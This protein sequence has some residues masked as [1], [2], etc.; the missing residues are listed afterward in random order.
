MSNAEYNSHGRFGRRQLLLAGAAL[1]I[2]RFR[3]RRMD[4][5]DA[6]QA[7]VVC[8]R[9]LDGSGTEY[10]RLSRDAQPRLD[11]TVVVFEGV[12]WRIDYEIE[13]DAAWR[14]RAVRVR[15]NQG[16]DDRSLTLEVR[17]DGR[18]VVDTR[19]R[20]DLQG[21]VDVDL[22]FSPSTNTLPIRRL[23]MQVQQSRTIAVAWVEFPSLV[24]HRVEQR[25]TRISEG[26]Y[27]YDNLPT[28]FVAELTV[29]LHGLVISYPPGWERVVK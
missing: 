4:L 23:P 2:A 17:P 14:T 10:C 7:D 11:G 19:D 13:C 16:A 25:Y 12:P 8:W 9:R 21:C 24:V 22:G 27:R 6:C 15:A 28:G 29:D 1:P 18:W 3:E 26:T 5:E 20:P